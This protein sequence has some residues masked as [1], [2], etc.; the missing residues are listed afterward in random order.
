M[1][2]RARGAREPMGQTRSTS[3]LTRAPESLRGGQ[4]EGGGCGRLTVSLRRT[5]KLAQ[6]LLCGPNCPVQR[7]L[8]CWRESSEVLPKRR[9]QA[10]K[11]ATL[12]DISTQHPPGTGGRA[13]QRFRACHLGPGGSTGKPQ[14]QR[15]LAASSVV[16]TAQEV[17]SRVQEMASW[18][19]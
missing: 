13:G 1:A 18:A 9:R 4:V 10:T 8:P 12:Q 14:Q 16:P 15:G 11:A 7:F 5:Q 6:A 19:T 17:G 2:A 3:Q